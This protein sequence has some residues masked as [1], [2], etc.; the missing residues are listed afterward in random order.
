M[1]GRM[2]P[3]LV[4]V[5]IFAA[6]GYGAIETRSFESDQQRE[7]YEVLVNE[8]RCPKC[9]NQNIADSNAPIAQDM[10]E[11]VY[12]QLQSG[13]SNEQ[14]M[15]SLVERFGDFVRYRPEVEPRT[16]FLWFGPLLAAIVGFLI[17]WRITRARSRPQSPQVLSAEERLKANQLL[18]ES[19]DKDADNDQK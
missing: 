2:I 12:Q 11:E 6:P 14:V 8:L 17:V 5:L 15:A 10:R 3:V 1:M 18:G 7:R 13:K 4:A 9:Q 19:R 16:W